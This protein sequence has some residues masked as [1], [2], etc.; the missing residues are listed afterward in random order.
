VSDKQGFDVFLLLGLVP[1]II[2]AFFLIVCHTLSIVDLPGF[3][4]GG[5]APV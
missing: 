4:Q 3:F 2:A 5:A 1:L